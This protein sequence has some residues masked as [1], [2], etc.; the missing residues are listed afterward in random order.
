MDNQLC[1]STTPE[2]FQLQE[3]VNYV[4]AIFR[5]LQNQFLKT[6]WCGKNSQE[7]KSLYMRDCCLKARCSINRIQQSMKKKHKVRFCAFVFF[8]H[9]Q[10][11]KFQLLGNV[12]EKEKR[13]EISRR[14]RR[15]EPLDQRKCTSCVWGLGLSLISKS[16]T[17]L[18]VMG[19][20][21]ISQAET[22]T[23][24]IPSSEGFCKYSLFC[25]SEKDGSSLGP[26]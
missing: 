21:N 17:L 13:E 4:I 15:E 1:R 10:K 12:F 6:R 26:E 18:S 16:L 19:G 24:L 23:V 22:L 8:C 11:F 20:S 7:V 9:I 14:K 5:E 3:E 2:P 25:P